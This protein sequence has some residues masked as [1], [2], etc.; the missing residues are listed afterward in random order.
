MRDWIVINARQYIC[1]A[2]RKSEDK[3]KLWEVLKLYENNWI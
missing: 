1:L 3:Q 2:I